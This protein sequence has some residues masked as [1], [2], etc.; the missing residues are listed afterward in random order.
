MSYS[1]PYVLKYQGHIW[2]DKCMY[3]IY[4]FLY[5]LDAQLYIP[6]FN[7]DPAVHVMLTVM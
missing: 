3:I 7:V 1:I 6:P 2:C 4:N 5:V